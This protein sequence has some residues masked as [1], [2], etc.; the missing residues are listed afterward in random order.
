[1]LSRGWLG[2][3]KP[4]KNP[5]SLEHLR[6]LH[7]VL[8]KNHTI[9]DNNKSLIVEALRSMSEILIWGD[10]ND[11][12]VFEFY[13]EKN[14]FLFFL[15]ILQQNAGNYVCVQ[16]LQTLNILFE[17]LQHETSLYYLL[18]N[19]HINDV[20]C[21]KFDF[22]DEEVMAYYISF[23]KTL[24]LR[25]NEHTIHFFY[26]EHSDD[27]ALYTE[28]IKFFNHS[29]TMVRIAV[30]TLT[31]NVYKVND[32]AMLRFICDKTAVPYFSNLVWFIAEHVR[33]VDKC[34]RSNKNHQDSDR[35]RDLVAEHLDHMHYLNDILALNNNLLNEVLI[36][37]LLH[38]L[39]LP[40]YVHSLADGA[41]GDS[42]DVPM[43][44]SVVALFL[45]S[46]VFLIIH[47]QPLVHQLAE[48]IFTKGLETF[49]MNSDGVAT[50][51]PNL[52]EPPE[53]LEKLLSS[54]ILR[55]KRKHKRPNFRNTDS[56]D[57]PE[58]RN[59]SDSSENID[60]LDQIPVGTASHVFEQ[61]L[62]A[63]NV[64]I[65]SVNFS[66]QESLSSTAST[67]PHTPTD[68]RPFLD[69]IYSALNCTEND[70]DALFALCL[71]YAMLHNRGINCDLKQ[72]VALQ[73]QAN[74]QQFESYSHWLIER[75]LRIISK[76]VKPESKV[77]LATLRL[78]SLLL[79]ELGMRDCQCV[80]FEQHL[81]TIEQYRSES[82]KNL[83][84]RLKEEEI[85]LDIFE[86]EYRTF[87]SKPLNVEYLMM[88]SSLLLPPT[89]TPL[90]GIDFIKRLP[91]GPTEQTRRS[92]GV[93]FTL[94]DLSL[95]LCKEVETQ[96]PLTRDEDLIKTDDK[97]DLND[98]DLI[99]CTVVKKDSRQRRF[100]VVELYQLVLVEPD[101][102]RLGWGVV[103]F[104]GLLQDVEVSSDAD[105]SRTLHVTIHNPSGLRRVPILAANFVFDDHIRCMAAKQ[106]LTKGRG[107]ARHLKTRRIAVLLGLSIET[108]EEPFSNYLSSAGYHGTRSNFYSFG[109]RQGFRSDG[110]HHNFNQR[111]PTRTPT[112]RVHPLLKKP[113][114]VTNRIAELQQGNRIG[115]LGLPVSSSTS[116]P[117]RSL[118]NTR[119]SDSSSSNVEGHTSSDTLS[120]GHDL[121]SSKERGKTHKREGSVTISSSE[122]PV[123]ECGVE[124]GFEGEAENSEDTEVA[125]DAVSL[126]AISLDAIS[127]DAISVGSFTM[128]PVTQQPSAQSSPQTPQSNVIDRKIEKYDIV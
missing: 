43:V 83:Q 3:P 44:S 89:G 19:N 72:V 121:V 51:Q 29:E 55:K 112:A 114:H 59:N 45:L 77:R 63:S 106:R 50:N 125:L 23:L 127:Q 2:G 26:N 33:L 67:T 8:T 120:P 73:N 20:I 32:E 31:L 14:M 47:H 4:P 86:D 42:S 96:L 57:E 128:E 6:Y 68:S 97:L 5:H 1:M 61:D 70:Y 36:E 105:D 12:S 100:L 122:L 126:D 80:F 16:L 54:N 90:T 94:R 41:P 111:D 93:F 81:T 104:A 123:E 39:F 30:R 52:L 76:A 79:R 7:H 99:A 82:I 38:R 56:D 9:T 28:G 53:S 117:A 91:C 27:F 75:L 11:S 113:G 69:T 66:R 74:E 87:K 71:L 17:N 115:S 34:V 118:S 101:S 102:K 46:Q 35:L 84:S 107:R 88:D 92:I 95:T 15:N 22:S 62:E 98:S 119:S 37:H 13:L 124:I 58:E 49:V 24:S 65:D 116:S 10:Q 108:K 110:Q 25:L 60:L 18:S 48:V 103:K 40:L 85:F 78:N 109:E 21:H 64:P